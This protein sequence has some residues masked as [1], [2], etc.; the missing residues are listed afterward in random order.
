MGDPAGANLAIAGRLEHVPYLIH[1]RDARFK[2]SFEEDGAQVIKTPVRS[3]R[4]N[5][6][7]E[8]RSARHASSAWITC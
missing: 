5:A 7:A 8:R 3:K 6:I 2:A 1:D 4:A